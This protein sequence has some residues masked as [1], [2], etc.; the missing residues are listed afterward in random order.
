MHMWLSLHELRIASASGNG[1]ANRRLQWR[2]S[3]GCSP[4]TGGVSA[5]TQPPLPC[6]LTTLCTQRAVTCITVHAQCMGHWGM[7]RRGQATGSDVSLSMRSA[8]SPLEIQCHYCDY[9][10]SYGARP[11]FTLTPPVVRILCRLLTEH[12]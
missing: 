6:H 12:W 10:L 11:D 4:L 7:Q 8:V 1:A 3:R 2:M 5:S 9:V